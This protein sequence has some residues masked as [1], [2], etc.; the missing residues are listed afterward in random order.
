MANILLQVREYIRGEIRNNPK[1]CFTPYRAEVGGQKS[2]Y[3]VDLMAES[4]FRTLIRDQRKLFPGSDISF[5]GEESIHNNPDLRNEKGVV[6]LSDI[7]DGTDLLYRDFANWCSAVIVFTPKDRRV[8]AAYVAVES[9]RDFSV[10]YA[11]AGGRY[12]KLTEPIMTFAMA[13]KLHEGSKQGKAKIRE[14]NESNDLRLGEATC[15]SEASVCLYAQKARNLRALLD[16]SGKENFRR[17]LQT[18][19]AERKPEGQGFRFYN[20]AGNPMM[21]RMTDGKVDVVLDLV[22]QAPHDVL[23]GAFIAKSLGA[24]FGS[25]DGRQFSDAETIEW[26]LKPAESKIKYVLAGNKKLYEEV[27]SL[28]S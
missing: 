2:L 18:V 20:L 13:S 16:L 5:W 6:I 17:W 12:G 19:D 21:A 1:L 23:P 25:V 22:G 4:N 8:E 14:F 24:V 26:L 28:L 10:Y 9:G 11:L 3:Q 15:L 7:I 27:V